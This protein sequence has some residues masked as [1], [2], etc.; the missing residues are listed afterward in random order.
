[1]TR[2]ELRSQIMTNI[3]KQ[4]QALLRVLS[5]TFSTDMCLLRPGVAG[6]QLVYQFGDSGKNVS[7][8]ASKFNQSL[9]CGHPNINWQQSIPSQLAS[10]LDTLI[11][12]S[13]DRFELPRM[14]SVGDNSCFVAARST[15]EQ[16]EVE[17][18]GGIVPVDGLRHTE[19]L[20][21]LSVKSI[22]MD[23]SQELQSQY[24][25]RLSSSFEELCFLRRLS[26]NIEYCVPDY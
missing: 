20:L 9:D 15:G 11:D 1:M 16:G 4:S 3:S 21:Q 17:V 14:V 23:E 22:E 25:A 8:D 19:R 7:S 24:A 5:N 2:A 10:F 12:D 18:V 26:Q 13:G 6:W